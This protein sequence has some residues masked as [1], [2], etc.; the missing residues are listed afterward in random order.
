MLTVY[1]DY[2]RARSFYE[3]RGW[4]FAANEE[5]VGRG[6]VAVRQLRYRRELLQT[7]MARRWQSQQA[8]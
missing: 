6:G 5:D 4:W 2:E 1:R 3:R 7:A 8:G